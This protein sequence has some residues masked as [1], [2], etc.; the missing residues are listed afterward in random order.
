MLTEGFHV[1]VE[2]HLA[3]KAVQGFGD[4]DRAVPTG[5][6]LNGHKADMPKEVPSPVCSGKH[7]VSEPC[8]GRD[9]VLLSVGAGRGPEGQSEQGHRAAK[10][11]CSGVAREEGRNLFDLLDSDRAGQDTRFSRFW[12]GQLPFTLREFGM[13][14]GDE[15]RGRSCKW[16][17]LQ[18]GTGRVKTAL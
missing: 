10:G 18:S 4:L 1:L 12:W 9:V 5:R 13:K 16:A 2:Q 6:L 14:L 7:L 3:E 17:A 8:E 11:T 15:L